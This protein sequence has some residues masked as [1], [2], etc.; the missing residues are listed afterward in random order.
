M[1]AE[2]IEALGGGCGLLH[3]LS[4]TCALDLDDLEAARAWWAE[5]SVDIDTLRNDP[6]SVHI[7]SGRAGR[8]KLLYKLS[9]P[10]RTIKPKGSGF[11][12]RCATA[13]GES[14][15]D[16]L[17]PSVHPLT[18]KPYQWAYGEPLL[19][20]WTNLPNIPAG[21]YRV[22]REMAD[23]M[24]TREVVNQSP[25]TFSIARVR[26]AALVKMRKLD[27]DEYDDWINI[28]QS[29]HKETRGHSQGLALWD[30]LSKDGK[31]YKGRDDLNTH[32]VS[33]DDTGARGLNTPATAE[34]FEVLK[35][36]APSATEAAATQSVKE[37]YTAARDFLKARLIYVKD[38]E[39]YFDRES[40][41][42]FRSNFGLEH[43]FASKMPRRNGTRVS[44][45]KMLK[46]LGADKP[47]VDRLGFHPG[48][49][50]VF[51]EFKDTY[52]NLYRPRIADPIPATAGELE[53]IEWLF[54]RIDDVPYREWLIQF[55]GHVIQRPGVKIKSAPLIWSETQGNGKTT[56]VAKIPALLV[57]SQ[58]SVE[59][60]SSVLASDFNDILRGAWHVNL[61]EFSVGSRIERELLSKKVERWI[62][63]NK[64]DL[65]Q[66][67]LAAVTIPNHF[68]L[69][70]SSNADNAASLDNTDRKWGVHE[71]HAQAMTEAEM[72]WLFE[73]FLN[74]P[75]AAGVLRHYFLNVDLTGFNPDARAPLTAAKAAM[76]RASASADVE[77]MAELFEQRAGPFDKDVVL[78]SDVREYIYTR[79]PNK[80]SADR[81]GKVLTRSP[82]L[83]RTVRFRSGKGIYRA[84]VLYN[85]A[86]WIDARGV[87][88]MAHIRGDD[89]SIE[90][91]LLS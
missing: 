78:T 44:V 37:N 36:E 25:A 3:A 48:E 42:I 24:P 80:P 38:F 84:I 51:T 11:E 32:W 83:G 16:V 31:K 63:E 70:A 56:L 5:H 27:I 87:E 23:S 53:R 58:Y 19:G 69:T 22:W 73:G 29:I 67:G 12:L 21:V 17:P 59:M 79:C 52:A 86:R 6:H 74:T 81:I 39:Q 60:S 15:Q 85:H 75:R 1:P 28:G 72:T 18:K 71:L 64:I 45:V 61:S 14:V 43:E 50:I 89:V 10:L 20:H 41:R 47:T 13:G 55:Y 82:F 2:S 90:D 77:L 57:G 34:E 62:V 91:P 4:G 30:E 26:E 33:F 40:H 65:H 49:G 54:D 76:A 8:D 68:F 66:K 35:A 46:D 7:T 88:I 9:K